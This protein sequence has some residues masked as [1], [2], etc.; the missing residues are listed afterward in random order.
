MP[1][2]VPDYL[3]GVPGA[4][5]LFSPAR[6]DLHLVVNFFMAFARAEWA[7]KRAGFFSAIGKRKE[8]IRDNSIVR[9]D[10]SRPT[11]IIL[12]GSAATGKMTRDSDIDL[13]VVEPAPGDTRERSVQIR[14]TLSGRQGHL[15]RRVR[16]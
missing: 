8:E 15:S 9:I 13:L 11:K 2:A 6:V 7:L 14:G 4:G 5:Q 3:L 10:A 16:K 12:F 1:F